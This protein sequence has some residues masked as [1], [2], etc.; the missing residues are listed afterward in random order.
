MQKEVV[1]SNVRY[2]G[3]KREKGVEECGV[4]IR[5]EEGGTRG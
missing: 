1:V 2:R 3:G 4:E 5:I